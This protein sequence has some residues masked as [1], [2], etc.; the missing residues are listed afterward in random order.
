MPL[1]GK[2]LL[3]PERLLP[4]RWNPR[5]WKDNHRRNIALAAHRRGLEPAS[6]TNAAQGIEVLKKEGRQVVYYDDFL[7][8]TS[9]DEKLDKNEKT[10]SRVWLST[11]RNAP[12]RS[13]FF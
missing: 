11:V 3:G 13:V 9:L 1:N 5:Y 4:D 12:N 7:G 10:T 2:N 6:I 8:Q